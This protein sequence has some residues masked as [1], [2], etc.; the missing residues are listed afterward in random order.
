MY[1]FLLKPFFLFNVYTWFFDEFLGWPFG[2][3]TLF[4]TIC[5]LMPVLTML[6]SAK[7]WLTDRWKDKPQTFGRY[8][9]TNLAALALSMTPVFV[10]VIGYVLLVFPLH[11][12][13][14][15]AAARIKRQ[16]QQP[17]APPPEI[18]FEAGFGPAIPDDD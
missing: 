9:G 16:N 7:T 11:A 8:L 18:S 6:N 14:M 10:N 13:L 17:K 12:F 5:V 1:E 4:I 15:I 2:V 3:A